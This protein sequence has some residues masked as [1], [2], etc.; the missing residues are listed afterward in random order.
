MLQDLDTLAAR[1]GQLVQLVRQLQA[2]RTAMQSQLVRM[3]Q[4]RNALRDLQ[5]RQQAEHAAATQRL[6]EHSSEVD[7]V[8]AQADASL[9]ALRAQAESAQLE[10]RLE[11]SRYR[12]DYEKAE[13]SLQTSATESARLRAVAVAAKERLDALLERLPGAPQE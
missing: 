10:L 1:I 12:A 4:E 6:A 11:V 2:E 8:R 9:E 7:T 5:A 13:Q 3:E